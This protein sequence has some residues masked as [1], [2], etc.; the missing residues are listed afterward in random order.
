MVVLTQLL[1]YGV[2]WIN[3]SG[4]L[5]LPFDLENQRFFIAGASF[6]PQDFIYLT[7]ML[8][9]SAIGLFAWTAIG[10]R[11]WCGFACPQTM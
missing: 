2:P 8:L 1:F 5:A 10:G 7:A 4:H 3:I 9:L 11:L 6:L